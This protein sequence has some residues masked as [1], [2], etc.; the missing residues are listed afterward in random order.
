MIIIVFDWRLTPLGLFKSF[1]SIKSV[2]LFYICSNS[3]TYHMRTFIFT[4]T[5]VLL[6][7]CVLVTKNA[8]RALCLRLVVTKA[9]LG[10]KDYL[11]SF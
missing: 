4:T 6:K 3:T 11:L 5:K 8:S 7:R 10:H 9:G 1:K 2:F